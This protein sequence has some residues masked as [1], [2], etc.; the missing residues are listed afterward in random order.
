ML[1]DFEGLVSDPAVGGGATPHVLRQL[2]VAHGSRAL[3]VGQQEAASQPDCDY[4]YVLQGHRISPLHLV[5]EGG[6]ES[7]EGLAA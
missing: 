4:P 7:V 3:V 6:K 2:C 1:L 5:D